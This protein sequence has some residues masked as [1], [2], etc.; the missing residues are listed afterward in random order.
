MP[1]LIMP[2]LRLRIYRIERGMLR[3]YE[4]ISNV[5]YYYFERRHRFGKAVEMARQTL[6]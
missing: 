2:S 3:R 6:P 4:F 1:K 5:F